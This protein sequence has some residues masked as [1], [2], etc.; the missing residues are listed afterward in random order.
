MNE[1][2]SHEAAKTR[3]I[4]I[5]GLGR[6]GSSLV[7]QMLHAAGVDCVGEFPDFEDGDV[8]R[9]LEDDPAAFAEATE[10]RAVKILN[11]HRWKLP[12]MQGS[13]L[14]WLDRNTREQ[15]KSMIKLL[16]SQFSI[17]QQDRRSIGALAASIKKDAPKARKALEQACD[18]MA[19]QIDFENL[20]ERPNLTSVALAVHL[21]MKA[22]DIAK[23]AGVVE[24]RSAK[25]LPD[26]KSTR[27]NSSH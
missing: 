10:G 18:S 5:A 1:H 27:L 15:A 19:A 8:Q 12:P 2:I 13:M 17:I 14:L 26:R 7:M 22:R 4:I 16:S 6:C 21:D 3:R 23:M 24:P 20:V 25:C 9:L 11:A